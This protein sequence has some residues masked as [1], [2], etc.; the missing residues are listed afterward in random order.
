MNLFLRFLTLLLTWRLRPRL[1]FFDEA[2]TP[3]CVWPTDLDPNLHMNNGVYLSIMDLARFD[4]V[5]RTGLV[6]F[7]KSE[8]LYPVVASQTIRYRRSLDP[9]QRFEVGTRLV[10]WDERFFFIQQRFLVQGEV[11]ALAL[12]KGR[13]LKKGGKGVAPSVLAVSQGLSAESPELPAWVNSWCDSENQAWEAQK[14]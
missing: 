3:F 5:F 4:L 11:Y 6:K 1:G 13:F 8:G 2:L 12:V 7:V 10:G 14:A 9:F